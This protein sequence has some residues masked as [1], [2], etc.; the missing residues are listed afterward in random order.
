MDP[1]SVCT[2]IFSAQVALSGYL[3]ALF[4]FCALQCLMWETRLLHAI[5]SM[6]RITAGNE[7]IF[8]KKRDETKG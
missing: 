8:E 3:K 2:R 4:R 6:M 1:L 7:K 5:A